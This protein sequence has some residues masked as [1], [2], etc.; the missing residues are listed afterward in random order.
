MGLF[1]RVFSIIFKII[2]FLLFLKVVGIKPIYFFTLLIK[3]RYC[4]SG[5]LSFT[6]AA[7]L[8]VSV[9]TTLRNSEIHLDNDCN[10]KKQPNEKVFPF[11]DF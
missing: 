1:E 7:K 3:Y 8:L 6:L 2:A 10:I 5:C 11:I 4:I 9:K